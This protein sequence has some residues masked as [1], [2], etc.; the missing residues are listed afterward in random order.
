LPPLPRSPEDIF[1][2]S[3]AGPI[4]G[5]D[6]KVVTLSRKV[7]VALPSL[8]VSSI[9]RSAIGFSFEGGKIGAAIGTAVLAIASIA[10]IVLFP[11]AGIA[12]VGMAAW[13]LGGTGALMIFSSLMPNIA[14]VKPLCTGCRLLPVIKEHEAIH[15]S[16]VD[17]DKD[18]W[19]IMKQ[20]HSVES[21]ALVGDPRICSFCPI[22][23]RLSE[24]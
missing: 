17:S 14:F 6:T 12:A 11:I 15:L 13:L 23:K 9:P 24:H 10:S 5:N 22:A 21:L 18:V 19:A 4:F 7:R 16:G 2:P 20:R 3:L 1:K 8:L